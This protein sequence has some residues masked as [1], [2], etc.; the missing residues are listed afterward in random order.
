MRLNLGCGQVVEYGYVNCDIRP[1]PGVDVVCSIVDLSKHFNES[2]ADE[3][4]LRHVLEHVPPD[5]AR[6]ALR[7]FHKVLRPGGFVRIIVPDL[8]F[9]ARQLLG[10][11]K[12]SAEDQ[13]RHVWASLYGWRRTDLGGDAHDAHHWGY[14][15]QELRTFLEAAGFVRAV[16]LDVM[17]PW[18]LDMVSYR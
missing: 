2:S 14:D 1:G 18:H 8:V 10:Q 16:R 11:V 7:E 12:S 3:I 13:R 6:T 4:K 5:D 9:H 15:E 17:R